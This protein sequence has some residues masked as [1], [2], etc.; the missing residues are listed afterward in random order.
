MSLNKIIYYFT[1]TEKYT[2]TVQYLSMLYILVIL[3]SC[4]TYKH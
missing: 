3:T 2:F 1:F 4:T